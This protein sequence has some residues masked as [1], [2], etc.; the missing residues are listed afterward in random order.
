MLALIV[1]FFSMQSLSPSKKTDNNLNLPKVV[2]TPLDSIIKATPVSINDIPFRDNPDVYQYDDPGSVVF[3]Y[4]T[5]RKG[6][7]SENTDST[8]QQINNSSKWFY[9]GLMKRSSDRR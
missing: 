9:T 6:N 4:V 1:V 5:I 8:W 2:K 3:M 7:K